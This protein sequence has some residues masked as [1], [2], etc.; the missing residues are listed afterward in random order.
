M[1]EQVYYN[2]HMP[3]AVYRELAAQLGLID[4]LTV[5]LLPQTSCQFDYALS[6][7]EG[8]TLK[9]PDALP[10][11]ALRQIEVVL[12]HYGD[13]HGGWQTVAPINAKD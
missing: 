11:A 6:Q 13:R 5:Q 10:A 8:I 2:S 1:K 9:F 4:G 7:V 3:L 12:Q